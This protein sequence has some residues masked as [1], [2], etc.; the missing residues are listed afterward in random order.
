[1]E[2]IPRE[3]FESYLPQAWPG[4][5]KSSSPMASVTVGFHTLKEVAAQ[6]V[7]DQQLET[8]RFRFPYNTPTSKE[9]YLYRRSLKNCSRFRAPLSACLAGPSVARSLLLKR[10]SGMRR[11]RKWTIR[12]VV[13]LAFTSRRRK[14]NAKQPPVKSGAVSVIEVLVNSDMQ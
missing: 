4:G 5:R 12:L 2:D 8:A 7:S 14:R 13:R 10:L 3:C 1:M 11:S 9:A 6:Q